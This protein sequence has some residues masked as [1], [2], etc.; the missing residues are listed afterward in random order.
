MINID[1]NN[2]KLLL[3]KIHVKNYSRKKISFKVNSHGLLTFDNWNNKEKKNSLITH[4][5]NNR[6]KLNNN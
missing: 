1:Y 3:K 2:N 4:F 6:I 5:T